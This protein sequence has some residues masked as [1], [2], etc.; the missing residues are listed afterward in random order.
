MPCPVWWRRRRPRPP[1]SPV[2]PP[3]ARRRAH[4][5]SHHRPLAHGVDAAHPLAVLRPDNPPRQIQTLRQKE[6]AIE[7]LEVDY[8]LVIPFT[9]DFSLTEPEDFVRGFLAER[10]GDMLAG[11]I[12]VQERM[13]LLA[14]VTTA[15]PKCVVE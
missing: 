1:R 9:R 6:E 11:T 2:R 10:L 14:P 4:G 15:C 5:Q 8:L 7:A 3:R 13:V 12:V